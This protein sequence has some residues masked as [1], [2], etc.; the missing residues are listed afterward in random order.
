MIDDP[1]RNAAVHGIWLSLVAHP[2]PYSPSTCS[3][4]PRVE[5]LVPL[6]SSYGSPRGAPCWACTNPPLHYRRAD[7]E[8]VIR[9]RCFGSS[10]TR[11]LVSPSAVYSFF[12]YSTG[13]EPLRRCWVAGKWAYEQGDKWMV[14]R[15]IRKSNDESPPV[16]PVCD[17]LDPYISSCGRPSG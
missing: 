4:Y 7:G 6:G 3:R 2:S 10:D 11:L 13:V 5:R 16:N 17:H 15:C 9:T 12:G 1:V 8:V 14:R